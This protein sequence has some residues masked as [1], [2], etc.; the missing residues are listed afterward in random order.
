MIFDAAEVRR[1]L[2]GSLQP[3]QDLCSSLILVAVGAVIIIECESSQASLNLDLFNRFLA[4]LL[5]M[6]ARLPL[7]QI[8]TVGDSPQILTRAKE[9]YVN[10]IP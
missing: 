1:K 10:R 7:V 6:D 8:K 9:R 4:V 3:R 5:V 2:P